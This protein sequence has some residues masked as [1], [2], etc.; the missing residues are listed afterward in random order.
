MRRAAS[1]A[2]EWLKNPPEALRLRVFAVINQY[3][4]LRQGP[5]IAR[6]Y[7]YIHFS[8][9]IHKSVG[10]FKNLSHFTDKA[11]IMLLAIACNQK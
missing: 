4:N 9:M 7:E 10:G 5:A 3:S 1:A 2:A 8:N 6:P 11:H